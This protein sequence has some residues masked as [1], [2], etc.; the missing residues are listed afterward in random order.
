[1]IPHRELKPSATARKI[2]KIIRSMPY[3][4]VMGM[5]WGYLAAA[6]PGLIFGLLIALVTSVIIGITTEL[7]EVGRKQTP[8]QFVTAYQRQSQQNQSP[9]MNTLLEAKWMIKS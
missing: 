2:K 5:I 1:M 8:H 9:N 3:L 6:L 4:V 7:S